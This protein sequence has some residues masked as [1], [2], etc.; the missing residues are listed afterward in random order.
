MAS[1]HHCDLMINYSSTITLE[2]FI[3][4]KPVINIAYDI[5]RE[6][7]FHEDTANAYT[8]DSYKP[9]V[10]FKSTKDST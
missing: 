3:Y 5:D 2:C 10:D 7:F 1:L 9:I 6:S 8:V 4:D